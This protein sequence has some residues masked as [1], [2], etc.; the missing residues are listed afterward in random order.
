[1]NQSRHSWSTLLKTLAFDNKHTNQSAFS[2]MK[3]EQDF[4]I[5]LT[6][7]QSNLITNSNGNI[8]VAAAEAEAAA[9]INASNPKLNSNNENTNL[10]LFSGQRKSGGS[11]AVHD[12]AQL[13]IEDCQKLMAECHKLIS[14]Y[15]GDLISFSNNYLS[16]SINREE[17]R[18]ER[19]R[20]YMTMKAN[21]EKL[22][23]Q[24]EQ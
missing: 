12:I 13:L 10:V 1:M 11:G 2:P 15:Q 20:C 23:P 8:H 3:L 5:G 21:L 14:K 4:D 7:S 24:V 18:S 6:T 19:I 22:L 16:E 9:G 17:L